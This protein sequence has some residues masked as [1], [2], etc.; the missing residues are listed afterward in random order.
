MKSNF[1]RNFCIIAHVDHGKT[2]LSDCFLQHSQLYE[3]RKKRKLLLDS[4]DLEKERGVTIK[5]NYTVIKYLNPLDNLI[6]DLNLIDTP[7]HADFGYEVLRSLAVCEGVILL[8]DA[9]QGIQ[10]QTIYNYKQAKKLNLKIIPVI[11]K[12]DLPE[13]ESEQVAK[14]MQDYFHLE[15]KDIHYISARNGLNIKAVLNDVIS[16]IPPPNQIKNAL[17]RP[18]KGFVYDSFFD[19]Y[20]GIVLFIKIL[21]GKLNP[22][23]VCYA[24]ANKVKFKINKLGIKIPD[25]EYKKE[26]SAGNIAFI[27][28]GLRN[29]K[30]D[31]VGETIVDE[32]NSDTALFLEYQK[33]QPVVYS[34]FYPLNQS[35]YP[36]F[37]KAIQKLYLNDTS[38][39]F[40]SCFNHAL[41]YGMKC[42]FL[43]S[44][45]LEI[46]QQRLEGEFKI[47]LIST[48]PSVVVK[49]ELKNTHEIIVISDA[50]KIKEIGVFKI[51]KYYEPYARVTII[52]KINY[53]GAVLDYCTRL[54]GELKNETLIDE[55]EL[56]IELDMP[57]NEIVVDFANNLKALTKGFCSYN[58]EILDYR[59]NK[60][61]LL[62]FS[63]N[64]KIVN[65]FSLI[66]HKDQ[67]YNVANKICEKLKRLIPAQN[68][69]VVIQGI[70]DNKIIARSEIKAL[71]KNVL[72]KCY[73]GDISRKRKLL[74]KQ[75]KG[76]KKMKM[77]G[78]VEVPKRVFTDFLVS[79]K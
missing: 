75:K 42:G 67:A 27:E 64:K 22:D 55:N 47:D 7:G 51:E 78:N 46:V 28:T 45:H 36:L 8:V 52:T 62:E 35:D 54:R 30:L 37:E 11:N 10:A 43:G 50:F 19:T 73:G 13:A 72:S 18:F 41:G 58:Y 34:C 66:V 60:L 76:K 14:T 44:L 9:C 31:L 56:E 33:V 49:V 3:N 15:L 77:L 29:L 21:S 40:H 61:G 20:K 5:A 23:K 25:F 57:L 16:K 1:I 26:V 6:Y 53:Y 24:I 71:R 38:L 68:F 70:F 69:N 2:T 63:F 65:Y 17:H 79:S 39:H 12:I 59:Y 32:G 74:E 48:L 4:M